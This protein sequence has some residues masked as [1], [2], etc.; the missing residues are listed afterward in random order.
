MEKESPTIDLLIDPVFKEFID[1]PI[2]PEEQKCVWIQEIVQAL[3][4][5]LLASRPR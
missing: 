3:N 2:Y 5:L 4:G 1:L